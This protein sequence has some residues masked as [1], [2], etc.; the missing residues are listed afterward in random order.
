MLKKI[1]IAT[2]MLALIATKNVFAQDV[3]VYTDEQNDYSYYVATES[4]VNKTIYNNNR[5]FDVKVTILWRGDSPE[6]V[7]YSMWENDGLVWY[8]VG[9]GTGMHPATIEPAKSIWKFGLKFLNMD[10]EISYN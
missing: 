1:L 3:W 9:A 8:N 10:Y 7:T 4:F 6:E 5:A 2:F